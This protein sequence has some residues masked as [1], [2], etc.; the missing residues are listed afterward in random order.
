MA[1]QSEIAKLVEYM[2]GNIDEAEQFSQHIPDIING[3][4][5]SVLLNV[6]ASLVDSVEYNLEHRQY[7]ILDD[8][9][10]VRT[11]IEKARK[12]LSK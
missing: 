8:E 1:K 6:L 3:C 5:K 4:K 9:D 12:L 10:E 7:F 2:Y 11:N